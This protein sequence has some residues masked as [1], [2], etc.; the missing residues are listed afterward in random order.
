M[1]GA[2]YIRLKQGDGPTF[3][4]SALCATKDAKYV[5]IVPYMWGKY[6]ALCVNHCVVVYFHS[7]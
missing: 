4:A 7:L 6:L 1:G 5:Q 2:H 3:E